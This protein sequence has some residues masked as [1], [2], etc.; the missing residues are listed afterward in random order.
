MKNEVSRRNK[1]KV[2]IL[3]LIFAI[4]FSFPFYLDAAEGQSIKIKTNE[5]ISFSFLYFKIHGRFNPKM[6][7][8]GIS[9]PISFDYEKERTEWVK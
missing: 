3:L 8:Q 9:K 2:T 5:S 4:L 6:T 1:G 7:K